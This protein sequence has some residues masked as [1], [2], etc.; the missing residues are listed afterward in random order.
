MIEL[1]PVNS[2]AIRALGWSGGTLVVLFHTSDTLYIH[3]G[4]PLSVYLG[5]MMAASMGAYY[6]RY[7]RGRYR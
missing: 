4:V 6:N 7:I 3:P 1:L 5:L 2:S